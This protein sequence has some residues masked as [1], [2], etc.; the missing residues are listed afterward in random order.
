MF[1]VIEA[2]PGQPLHSEDDPSEI[3]PPPAD[4]LCWLDLTAPQEADL[5]RL[6]E[7]FGFH[8]LALED[9]AHADQRP[10]AEAYGDYTFLVSQGFQCPG[11]DLGE[12]HW[13]ELHVFLAR[14]Y[15]V[16]V[17]EGA[18]PGVESVWKRV[19][20]DEALLRKGVDFVYYLLQ[21]RIVDDNFPILDLIA[22]ALEEIEDTV[23][24]G[25]VSEEKV[26]LARIFGLKSRLVQMRKILSPQRD[27]MA[28]LAR[29]GDPRISERAAF[30]FRDV[31]DHLARIV[32]SIEGNRDLLG[33]AL[34]ALWSTQSQRTNEIMKA[35]TLMSAIFM[36]LTFITGFFGQNFEHLPFGSD[37]L[38]YAM[39][40]SCVLLP[41]ALVWWFKKKRWF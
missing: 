3:G 14:N 36:P 28:L 37:A 26:L 38:M 20:G 7:R 23:M 15:I 22:D 10:K 24:T 5:A 11:G 1:R 39:V 19:A 6:G 30:Y 41:G 27:V 17:H 34:E 29:G 18:I 9:C 4:A 32:E 16:T 31:Y 40:A 2:K 35:L 21:D 25:T 13:H 8:P 12:L 33:N